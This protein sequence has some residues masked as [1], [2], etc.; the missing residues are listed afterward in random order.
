MNYFSFAWYYYQ[1]YCKIYKM[2]GKALFFNSKYVL[3]FF[4]GYQSIHIMKI[5]FESTLQTFSEYSQ[6]IW[7]SL[8]NLLVKMRRE[9]L[10]LFL[11]FKEIFFCI[12]F[13]DIFSFN[14]RFHAHI[15]MDKVL[16]KSFEGFWFYLFLICWYVRREIPGREKYILYLHYTQ[17][18][19]TYYF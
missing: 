10:Y 8:K 13:S 7:S 18:M 2:K 14:N 17:E 4:W 5:L 6:E 16:T 9:N 11:I 1:R 15:L 3:Y 12:C 19:H